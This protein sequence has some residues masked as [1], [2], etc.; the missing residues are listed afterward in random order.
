MDMREK[1]ISSFMTLSRTG[2]LYGVTTD[3]LAARAG[4]SKR[5]IYRYF[6]SKEE[7][8]EAALETF[9]ARIS[10]EMELI[11]AKEKTPIDI[12]TGIIKKVSINGQFLNPLVLKDL[13]QRYPDLWKKIE[14]FRAEKIKTMLNLLVQDNNKG[15]V[16]EVDPRIVSTAFLAS[17]QAVVNPDFIL[18]N[19]LT[20]EET[21]RQLIELFLYGFV[22]D[23]I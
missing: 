16:R 12:L 19:E 18:D 21:V 13:Q 8:I 14:A 22:K 2:G 20:F 23:E 7:I 3:E 11:L 1:I 6:R 10:R 15:F 9:M 17:V 5:T 4:I